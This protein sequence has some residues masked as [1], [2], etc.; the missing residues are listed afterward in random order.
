M[1]T[2]RLVDQ[3]RC[4]FVKDQKLEQ[5]SKT[6]DGDEALDAS[7]WRMKKKQRIIRGRRACGFTDDLFL[8]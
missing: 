8:Q 5:G 7:Q 4:V 2:T 6:L 3:C 1:E